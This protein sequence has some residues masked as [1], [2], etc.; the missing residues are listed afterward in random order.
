MGV[1]KHE[2]HDEF[3]QFSN[4]IDEL[5]S[6]DVSFREH[7]EQYAELDQKIEGLERRD[8]PLGDASL[9]QMKQQSLELK[10]ELYSV[11][12]SKSKSTG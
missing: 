2:L 8:S 12:V 3:P 6:S 4:L 10:D 1:S 7:F 11:L 9:H 5:K